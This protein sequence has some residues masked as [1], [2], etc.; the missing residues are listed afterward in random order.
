MELETKIANKVI[1][2]FL[3]SDQIFGD[4]WNKLEEIDQQFILEE[5][6]DAIYEVLGERRI[7]IDNSLRC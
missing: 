4:Y 3:N 7:N 5:L 2:T 1:Q 6:Q